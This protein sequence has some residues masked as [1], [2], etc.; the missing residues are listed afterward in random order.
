MLAVVAF[1]LAIFYWALRVAL[2][3]DKIQ[4]LVDSGAAVAEEPAAPRVAA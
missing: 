1:S 3:T 2:P 4:R